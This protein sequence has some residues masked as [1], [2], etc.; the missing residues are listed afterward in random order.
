M[1]EIYKKY[2]KYHLLLVVFVV[3]LLVCQ[4]CSNVATKAS[5]KETPTAATKSSSNVPIAQQTVNAHATTKIKLMNAPT[6]ASSPIDLNIARR[7]LTLP[8]NIVRLS[9]GATSYAL[10]RVAPDQ[11]LRL[12]SSPDNGVTWNYT[13]QRT[14]QP[15]PSLGLNKGVFGLVNVLSSPILFAGSDESLISVTTDAGKTWRQFTNQLPGGNSVHH[16]MTL[17]P[18]N[19]SAAPFE[20][21]VAGGNQVWAYLLTPNASQ[22][23]R[24]VKYVLPSSGNGSITAFAAGQTSLIYVAAGADLY[25]LA[26]NLLDVYFGRGQPKIFQKVH[27]FT[28]GQAQAIATRGSNL[29]VG[30]NSGNTGKLFTASGNNWTEVTNSGNFQAPTN[31]TIFPITEL[32]TVSNTNY[33]AAL[34][35]NPSNG[36]TQL[37]YTANSSQ[38]FFLANPTANYISDV[39][40]ASDG[41][42]LLGTTYNGLISTEPQVASLPSI[43]QEYPNSLFPDS[44]PPNSD[45]YPQ[46]GHFLGEPFRSYWNSHGGLAQF[47]YPITDGF[48]EINSDDGQV[49]LTQY[50]ERARMEYHPNNPPQYQI[51]LGLL[52]NTFVPNVTAKQPISQLSVSDGGQYFNSTGHSLSGAFLNYWQNNGG[53][54]QFGYPITEPF[55]EVNPAD[56]KTYTVQYFER[57]RLEYHPENAGTPNE[58]ELGLLGTELANR[59][60]LLVANIG[61]KAVS[62]MAQV[63]FSGRGTAFDQT[64]HSPILNRDEPYRIY[65]P[66]GYFAN[67]QQ[68]YPVLYMLHGYSGSRLE[69][70]NYGLFTE[71]DQL[72]TQGQIQPMIIVLPTGDQEY[73]VDHDKG[74]L[75]WGTYVA[76]DVVNYI[77]QNFRTKADPQDRAIGGLSMGGYGALNIGFN[78]PDVFGVVSSTSAGL[79]PKD[80]D[81]NYLGNDAWYADHDPISLASG[82]DVQTLSS[83]KIWIDCGTEDNEWFARNQL[84]DQILTDRGVPHVWLP[85]PGGHTV[86]YWEA[87]VPTLLNWYSSVLGS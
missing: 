21:W 17:V 82:L 64:L 53:L 2:I 74:G 23:L 6:N 62:G 26:D 13:D 66:P 59:R 11:K 55:Q 7:V 72:I 9:L 43:S 37:Y 69:W 56:G 46:T 48:Q 75:Q 78:Y 29:W 86:Q 51:L 50:F 16:F 44:N 67:P 41:N 3:L 73:W 35:T 22:V 30:V 24:L 15:L 52:G 14:A 71:A 76:Q 19:S 60:G 10:A 77:D 20:L 31:S 47:G 63:P 57:N 42:L 4:S 87:D 38:W 33:L 54:A 27:H 8:D 1:R 45:Y 34:A 18:G 39:G 70:F 84:L 49:Y 80:Q 58:V 79:R 40:L 12:F 68:R 65:L 85:Q 5:V 83:L 81:P 61:L 32:R 28:V 36:A 25:S